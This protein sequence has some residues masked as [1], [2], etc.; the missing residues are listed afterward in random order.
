[1]KLATESYLSQQA[2]WP[3]SGNHILAQFND[4]TIIVYQAYP[5][6]IAEFAIKNQYFRDGFSLNRMSWIKTNFLWMMYRSNWARNNAQEYILAI[7]LRLETFD[8]ILS[9]AV[10]SFYVNGIYSTIEE[11]KSDIERSSVRIQWDPDHGPS[12]KDLPRRAI[13]LG[14][15][16]EILRKY[17]NEWILDI[18][19]VTDFVVSQRE[20]TARSVLHHLVT[21]R[22]EVYLPKDQSL[23]VRLGLTCP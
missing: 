7:S 19:D 13:Q 6:E 2:R 17:A 22:E 20:Y 16:R 3:T 14:L 11:W 21:P 5:Q 15:R 10:P 9:K 8:L 1:M 12:G 23:R 18:E 4:K